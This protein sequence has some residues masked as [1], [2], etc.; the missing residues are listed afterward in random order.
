MIVLYHHQNTVTTVM[1]LE[2]GTTIAVPDSG[3]IARSLLR[4]ATDYPD[5]LLLWCD[6]N[7]RE[8]LHL[9][10]IAALFP[11]KKRMLSY[12]IGNFI[13]D[14]IGYVDESL[15]ANPNRNVTF[16][17]WQM[18]ST[19][20]GIFAETVNALNGLKADRNFAYFLCSL[21]KLGMAI[22]LECC[23]E[24]LLL[25]KQLDT[26]VKTGPEASNQLL[27]RFAKQHYRGRWILMLLLNLFLYERKVT[28][29]PFIMALF[30]KRRT[31]SG[32]L[33][34]N[35]IEPITDRTPFA[36]DV[37]IPTIGR[38]MFLYDVLQD[39]S[40]QTLKPKSVILIEQNP[41]TDSNSELDYLA[42]ESWPFEII[43][44]FIHQTGACN[45]RNM[46]LSFVQSEWVF[47]ADDDIRFQ[48]DFLEQASREIGKTGGK[49]FTLS[50]R[51]KDDIPKDTNRIQWETF[52]SGCSIVHRD[53]LQGL[54]FD[55]RFENGFGEDTDFGMQLRNKGYDI[56][57]L[58][59]P[60]I[61][62]LKAPVGGFRTRP[63]LEWQIDEVQPKPSP[64]VML[65]RLLH[66][67]EQQLLG[68]KT[69][70]CIKFYTIQSDKNPLRYYKKFR[71]AWNRSTYWA[72]VLKERS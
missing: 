40:A 24:P 71:K 2:S 44:R 45:A 23:S 36:F 47:L 68:Y 57:Y 8:V 27:F 64:T 4:L 49:A 30:Y 34:N 32:V 50:C 65:F 14:A 51:Q 61:L 39:L 43:H 6:T 35:D 19:V 38:K 67:T 3:N 48:S 69:T 16:P 55:M 13:P 25:R 21:A 7:Y 10:K 52:G 53:A 5:R 58:P 63:V 70:L 66:Y 41:V 17:T 46:A 12:G 59:Q 31:L 15:F 28:L 72:N 26:K 18:H 1:D 33:F 37:I 54:K 22:G 11:H 56:L 20:G 60:E 9:E 29:F 42:K 62:H